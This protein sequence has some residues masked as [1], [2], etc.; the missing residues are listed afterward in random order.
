GIANQRGSTVV[1]DRTTG[2]PVGPGIGWQDLRTVGMCLVRRGQGIRVA[3][4]ESATKLAMLLDLA[5]P[6]RTRDLCFGTV[7][8]WTAWT[9]PEGAVHVTD[10]TNAGITGLSSAEGSA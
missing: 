1:W 8:T 10:A 5:E 9:L 4:S 3:P 2:E 6:D 7:D